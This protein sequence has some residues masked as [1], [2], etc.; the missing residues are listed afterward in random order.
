MD[1]DA[2]DFSGLK[3]DQV[4]IR[5]NLCIKPFPDMIV[6]PINAL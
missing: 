2:V 5:S 4:Q 1:K 3:L 6:Y